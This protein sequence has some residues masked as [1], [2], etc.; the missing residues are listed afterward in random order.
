VDTT[1]WYSIVDLRDKNHKKAKIFL[2]NISKPL[3]TSNYIFDEIIT[4]VKNKLGYKV[5]A[6]L[7]K[8]LIGEEIA[9][10]VRVTKEDE[11]NAWKI[12]LKYYDKGF[13]FTDCTSFIIIER[14]AI[15]EAFSFDQHFN[16]YGIIKLP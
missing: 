4:L 1:A 7:G 11:K 2:N 16:Q 5:A 10:I 6:E 12:F 13:S 9:Q 8:K 3:I 14:L 15:K